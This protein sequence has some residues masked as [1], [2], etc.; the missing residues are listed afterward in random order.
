MAT[1]AR[2]WP[3]AAARSYQSAA[4]GGIGGLAEP[5]KQHVAEMKLRRRH[6]GPR[7]RLQ[8]LAREREIARTRPPVQI[9]RPDNAVSFPLPIA[10]GFVEPAQSL[11]RIRPDFEA[12]GKQRLSVALRELRVTGGRRAVP[13]GDASALRT[14]Q[15]NEAET[16]LRPRM[17]T[18]RGPPIPLHRLGK[19][20]LDPLALDVE[21]RD[22]KRRFARAR[23]MGRA[24][25]AQSGKEAFP[26]IGRLSTFDVA[27]GE[28][29][30]ELRPWRERQS[31]GAAHGSRIA[32]PTPRT[33]PP[34]R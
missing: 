17:A 10:G 12:G 22:P 13:F 30:M 25:A 3:C 26:R 15:E 16:E 2:T 24:P 20:A 34:M 8:P 33:R 18:L 31:E 7:R 4:P 32:S 29:T 9:H 23:R 28:S 11:V 19:I 21:L 5:A 27:R 14:V 6:A 1:A